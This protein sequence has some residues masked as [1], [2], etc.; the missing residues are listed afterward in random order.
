WPIPRDWTI[1]C[2]CL[3]GPKLVQ[4]GDY[5]YL[6]VA[7]G[8]TAGPATSHMIISARS[9][10]PF[11]PWENS[12][13]NPID[14]TLSASE[15]WWSKGHATLFEDA[16]GKWWIVF[17]GYE[18]EFQNMGRQTLLQPIEWTNDGW[19]KIPGG[20]STDQPL[21]ISVEK[22]GNSNYCQSDDFTGKTLKPHWKF[23]G[24]YDPNRITPT[25]EG[26]IFRGKGESVGNSSPMLCIPSDHSYSAD[27]ELQV[28]KGGV[29]GLILFYNN[30]AYNGL[31]V[32]DN[33]IL[34]NLKGWQY[35]AEKQVHNGHVFL[36]LKSVN[37]LVD[38]YYS[39]DGID[40]RK[41]ES[42]FY[43]SALQHNALGGFLSLRIGITSMGNGAI[44]LK[45]F[46]YTAL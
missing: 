19:F 36:R 6:T 23:F 13:F 12:P 26:L 39:L 10:S 21:T 43:T 32:K 45:N 40:W 15:K 27:L 14:R 5:Y 9:K 16:N 46:V 33:D 11:G 41:L 37:N 25:K 8:G 28:E 29:G 3:E 38:M 20:A 22:T 42:S 34:V 18:K 7:E 44:I 2:F 17:H 35:V 4:R 30:S 1:E 24:E 31:L